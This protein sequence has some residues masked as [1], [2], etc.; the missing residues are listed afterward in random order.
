MFNRGQVVSKYGMTRL[1]NRRRKRGGGRGAKPPNN[2]RG[3]G[4]NIPFGP[5]NNPPTFSFNFYMN[6]Y[7]KPS[8]AYVTICNKIIFPY[9][10][11]VSLTSHYHILN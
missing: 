10:S 9:L 2:L 7:S 4:G 11:T 1:I 3:G 8:Y 6:Q 5:P